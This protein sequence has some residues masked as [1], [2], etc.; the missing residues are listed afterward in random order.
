MELSK[1]LHSLNRDQINVLNI[2]TQHM[3]GFAIDWFP[4]LPSSLMTGLILKLHMHGWIT[5]DDKNDLYLWSPQFPKSNI[6]AALN[7]QNINLRQNTS[8][9]FIE[10]QKEKKDESTLR[11]RQWIEI[12]SVL[13]S[14]EIKEKK[15]IYKD[16]IADYDYFLTTLHNINETETLPEKIQNKFIYA[17]QRRA[18]LSL[19]SP[20]MRKLIPLLLSA[21]KMA[22]LSQDP[23]MKASLELAIGQ[24]YWVALSM[25]EAI[26][27]WKSVWDIAE[28]IGDPVILKQSILMKVMLHIGSGQL[29]EAIDQ[30]ER[31]IGNIDSYFEEDFSLICVQGVSFVYAE[32]GIPQR[33]LGIC[34]AIRKQCKKNGNKP[35]CAVSYVMSGSILFQTGKIKGAKICF[36]KALGIAQKE[37]ID[38]VSF[39]A[40]VGLICTACREEDRKT[41]DKIYQTI[42]STSKSPWI[43]LLNYYTLFENFYSLFG[44]DVLLFNNDTGDF[45]QDLLQFDIHPV[46][47]QMIRRLQIVFQCDDP[48][49]KITKLKVL[50]GN[51]EQNDFELAKI[52]IEIARLYAMD[53]R[54]DLAERYANEAWHFLKPVAQDSFPKDLLYLIFPH[55]LSKEN[56]LSECV[57]E[58]GK[59]LITQG[60]IEGL[61][62][63]IITSMSKMTGAERSAIFV[64]DSETKEIKMIASRNLFYEN[65]G[66]EDFRMSFDAI[67][68][69]F[70]TRTSNISEFDISNTD[71]RKALILPLII[72]DQVLGVLYQ[73][74]RFFQFGDSHEKINILSA[75]ASQIA[76]AIDRA[77]AHDEIAKFN[78]RLIEENLYYIDEK[79]EFR[80]FGEIIGSSK[81][82]KDVQKVLGKVAPTPSTVLIQGETGVGKELIARAIHRESTRKDQPFIRVNC[83]ALP[84]SLIDSELFGHEKG[85]FTG[86]VKTRAGRFE[87]AH[88]GTLFLDEVSEI[89]LST[90]SR[91]LRVLQEK[92]F[93]RIG[94]TKTLHSDFRLITATNKDL[95]K[96]VEAGRFREDL[97]YRL[98]VYPIVVPPLRERKEDIPALAV[99][100]LRL[101]SSKNNKPYSGIKLTEIE[102]LKAHSWPGNIREFSNAMERAVIS[103]SKYRFNDL[104]VVNEKGNSWVNLFEGALNYKTYKDLEKK[105]IIEALK[106]CGGVLGGANGAS[107]LLGINRTTLIA[108]MKKLGI[109]LKYN[110]TTSQD[111]QPSRL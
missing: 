24:H 20:N 30:Y 91:L 62:T 73:D 26:T 97:F 32:A 48:S 46:A 80:P 19:F 101:F 106:K 18:G 15:H 6:Q 7:E 16:A 68:E 39:L 92:E 72:K 75:L 108:R 38:A 63:N 21:R 43:T 64:N 96:E 86:A 31:L 87:L 102:K 53:N 33:G 103:D 110:I 52:R 85:A 22:E 42:N 34:E 79:E 69:I 3:D 99:H 105:L 90:Q 10:I 23:K 13:D 11:P 51:I 100:F 40:K 58:M 4:E 83:A 2:I 37:N 56:S 44:K 65:L 88:Q 55:N 8:D 71:T 111:S 59:A 45:L 57:I 93:Q 54:K 5:H 94:G 9:S 104:I 84:E 29:L 25:K 61:L 14:A 67:H 17:A 35:L 78:K 41:A 98:N 74:S 36:E 47:A 77:R 60:S 1:F 81:A 89:P 82:I 50:E 27:H 76:L 12:L 70:R 28:S 95:K 109:E 66:E 49:N 107:E